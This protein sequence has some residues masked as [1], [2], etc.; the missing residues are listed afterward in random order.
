MNETMIPLISY[1][2]VA[3]LAGIAGLCAHRAVRAMR[4]VA[5]LRQA[6]PHREKLAGIV[7]QIEVDRAAPPRLRSLAAFL[8]DHAFDEAFIRKIASA[9]PVAEDVGKGLRAELVADCGLYAPLALTALD[10]FAK[11]VLALT[12]T[13]R[14]PQS[15]RDDRQRIAGIEFQLKT[16]F[17]PRALA[18]DH[19]VFAS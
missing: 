9:P 11:A 15:A 7:H 1:A 18:Q 10:A 13:G 14:P 19:G 12:D 6:W 2:G 8:A 4:R 16:L 17:A 3:A 5:A